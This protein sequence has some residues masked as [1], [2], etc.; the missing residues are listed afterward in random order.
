MEN[1]HANICFNNFQTVISLLENASLAQGSLL[2]L[3]LFR[4]FNL[5]LVDQLVDH[6]G[7]ASTFINNYFQWRTSRFAEENIRKI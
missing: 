7:G 3:I 2:S 4:F 5:D 6:Q 1:R